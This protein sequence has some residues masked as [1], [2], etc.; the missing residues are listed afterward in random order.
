MSNH[1]ATPGFGGLHEGAPDPAVAD[2]IVRLSQNPAA[3]PILQQ[4]QFGQFLATVATP[5][6]TSQTRTSA[7]YGNLTTVGPSLADLP[8][9]QYLLL[10]GAAAKC[11]TATILAVMSLSYNGAAA[12]DNDAVVSGAADFVSVARAVTTTLSTGDNSVD[13]KYKIST[14]AATATFENRWLVAIKYANP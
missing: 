11:D 1:W 14:T 2:L 8:D 12:S 6:L 13:A 5:I 10:F 4:Q 7:T 9:G 3:L